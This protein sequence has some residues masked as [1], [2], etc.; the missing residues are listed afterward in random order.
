MG[1]PTRLRILELLQETEMTVTEI[2]YRLEADVTTVSKHL[3]FL[4]GL[5]IV[6]IR[7]AGFRV[8]CVL[9]MP[10]LM[11]FVGCVETFIG[12]RLLNHEVGSDRCACEPERVLTNR[13]APRTNQ[14]P[15]QADCENKRGTN[16]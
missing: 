1:Q 15:F 11:V 14:Y 4:K 9:A 6:R 3:S 2:A 10:E 16:G 7:K 12:Q 5:G 13:D 8:Y